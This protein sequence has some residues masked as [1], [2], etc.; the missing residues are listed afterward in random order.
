MIMESHTPRNLIGKI[1]ITT[2][3][4]RDHMRTVFH[5]AFLLRY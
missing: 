5:I 4:T 2:A 3:A 1:S